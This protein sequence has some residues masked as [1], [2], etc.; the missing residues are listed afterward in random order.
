MMIVRLLG[1]LLVAYGVY[2]GYSFM[3]ARYWLTACWSL[4]AMTCGLGLIFQGRWAANV[5]YAFALAVSASWIWGV[6]GVIRSGWPYVDPWRSAIS[7][8]PG[9][10]I[11]MICGLGSIAVAKHF[12][13]QS[14]SSRLPQ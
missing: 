10:C 14:V 13:L 12:R 1:L 11:L 5:W 8:I 4:G 3:E 7:L 9:L 6:A 2:L